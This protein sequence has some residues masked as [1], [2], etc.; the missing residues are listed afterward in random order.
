M[1]TAIEIIDDLF[2]GDQNV[3][4]NYDELVNKRIKYIIN[5]ADDFPNI[6]NNYFHYTNLNLADDNP[7][8]LITVFNNI[9]N[10][11]VTAL[12]SNERVLI[13]CVHANTRSVS[14]IIMFLIKYKQMSL[15]SAI[16]LVKNKNNNIIPKM[17]YIKKLIEYEKN[18]GTSTYFEYD[19]YIDTTSKI[20]NI[21]ENEVINKLDKFC[22]KDNINENDIINLFF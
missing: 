4:N 10:F 6:Y 19:Y 14:I 13:H 18:I 17:I 21:S 7:N 9:Y 5:C 2:L 16:E 20:L 3:A 15:K 8:H 1:K 11:I 12:E 22:N